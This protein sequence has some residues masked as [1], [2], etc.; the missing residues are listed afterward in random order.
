MSGLEATDGRVGSWDEAAA[1]QFLN[2]DITMG[3]G[4]ATYE[5]IGS[6][7][8]HDRITATRHQSLWEVH[9]TSSYAF[10]Y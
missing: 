6:R 10:M 2:L 9:P 8:E 5:V 1:L 4:V 3:D 7:I